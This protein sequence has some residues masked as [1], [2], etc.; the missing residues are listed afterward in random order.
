[1]HVIAGKIIEYF[2][3]MM[4]VAACRQKPAYLV[5]IGVRVVFSCQ[6]HSD[7]P[8]PVMAAFV[9]P[10]HLVDFAVLLVG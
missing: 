4:V 10:D 7:H 1:M 5:R 3:V 2:P 8:H 9:L 6:M